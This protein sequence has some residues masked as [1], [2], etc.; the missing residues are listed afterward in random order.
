MSDSA[1]I[2]EFPT[3]F[4][5][6][7]MEQTVAD[8][9]AALRLGRPDLTLKIIDLALQI[10]ALMMQPEHPALLFR[11]AVALAGLGRNEDAMAAYDQLLAQQI[12]SPE[13]V[14]RCHYWRAELLLRLGRHAEMLTA[15]TKAVECCPDIADVLRMRA[16]ALSFN[17]RGDDAI[18]AYDDIV[19]RQKSLI[20][21][22]L[23]IDLITAERDAILR[24]FLES[25]VA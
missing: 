1:E 22:V 25:D 12:E 19:A 15:A 4:S 5:R 16:L 18:E 23:W 24:L 14:G 20:F 3:A 21:E 9:D 11:R 13:F 2:I 7:E 6:H 17:A 8:A 10:S